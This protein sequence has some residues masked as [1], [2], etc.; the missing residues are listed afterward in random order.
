MK[1]IVVRI[2]EGLGNQLF[3]YANAYALSKKINYTLFTDSTSGYFKKKNQTRAYELYK[4]NISACEINNALKHDTYLLDIKRKFYK[5]LDFIFYK[6]NF[7]IEN[8]DNNKITEYSNYSKNKFSNLLK[9]EGYFQSEKYFCD[10][11]NEL[12]SEFQIQNNYINIHQPII[13]SLK[14]ENSVSLSIRQNRFSE[15]KIINKD[16]SRLFI[17]D[18]INYLKKSVSFLKKKIR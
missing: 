2:A 18:T 6:K 9:V 14:K 5:K 17:K 1:K 10:F 13:N 15:G 11:K 3:M 8:I 16:K 4:F 7:L 12:I